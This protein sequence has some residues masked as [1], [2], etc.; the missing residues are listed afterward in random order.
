MPS[1]VSCADVEVVVE[2]AGLGD[3]GARGIEARGLEVR[4][5]ELRDGRVAV[6]VRREESGQIEQERP[7]VLLGQDRHGRDDRAELRAADGEVHRVHADVAVQ[8][9]RI[10]RDLHRARRVRADQHAR[11]LPLKLD[12]VGPDEAAALRPRVRRVARGLGAP[13]QLAP[14]RARRDGDGRTVAV[15]VERDTAL[16]HIHSGDGILEGSVVGWSWS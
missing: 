15:G 16:I 1:K 9:V 2:G 14:E 7:V 11:S 5:V 10:A 12:H 4:P 3:E 6:D 8:R 13:E